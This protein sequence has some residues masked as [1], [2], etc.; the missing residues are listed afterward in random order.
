MAAP[1]TKQYGVTP[2]I[3]TAGPEQVDVDQNAELIEE[4]KRENNYEP[5]EATKKRMATLKLLS[6]CVIEF[7]KHV[8]KRQGVP[9]SQAAQLGGK[10]FAYGSYRLGVYSPGSDI[11]TLAVAPKNIKREDFFDHFPDILRRFVAAED[12]GFLVPVRDAHVPIIKLELNNIEIDLNFVSVPGRGQIPKDLAIDNNNLLDGMDDSAVR[13]INGP[14]VTDDILSLIPEA[15]TFRTA[16]RAIKLWAKR[17]GIYANIVGFLGGV[18]WGMLVARVCQW[19]PHAVGATI[20]NKFFMT[21]KTWNWPK[22]IMLNQIEPGNGVR[23]VWNPAVYPGDR[24][25]L[26][27]VI[28]PSWPAMC[29]TYNVSKSTKDVMMKE[30]NR[31]SEITAKIFYGSGKWSDLFEKH[32]FF[33]KDHKYYMSIIASSKSKDDAKAWSGLVESKIRIFVN[34]LELMTDKISLARPF[35]KGYARNHSCEDEAQRT[36]VRKGKM[37]YQVDVT[38]VT[39][40]TIPDNAINGD[41]TGASGLVDLPNGGNFFTHTFYIGMNV[42]PTAQKNLNVAAPISYF[43]NTCQTWAGFDPNLHFLDCVVVRAHD[44]P[45]DCFDKGETKAPKPIKKKALA[46]SNE[47]AGISEGGDAKRQKTTNGDSTPV[48]SE[49]RAPSATPV[50]STTPVPVNGTPAPAATPIPSAAAPAPA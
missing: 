47:E 11:D 30:L 15:K 7:V 45:D 27:P 50:L 23:K 17:R 26:M 4:L 1:T 41:A 21:M 19:Y 40:N 44:L 43:K 24:K 42:V 46:R 37:T 28:T 8:S 16:L 34:Q 13:A 38:K 5:Q 9:D 25:N 14:R 33:T 20:V 48:P 29:S 10:I 39:E 35:V 2:A 32:S 12:I 18:Q 6:H 49:V 36:E 3:S 31:G 22:P